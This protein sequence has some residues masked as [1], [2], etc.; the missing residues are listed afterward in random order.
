[1]ITAPIFPNSYV[2]FDF[3]TSGLEPEWCQVIQMSALKVIN[4]K[5]QPAFNRFVK[6]PKKL[7]KKITE[8]TGITDE[9]LAVEG[10]EAGLAWREFSEY[11]GNYA[12]VGHNSINFDRLFLEAAIKSGKAQKVGV[13]RHIDTAMLYKAHKM[14][15][16][17][18]YYESHF[19]FATRI[20]MI[21]AKG[22]YFKLTLC[23]QELGI[24]V[25]QFTAHQSDSDCEMTN[26][27]YR[28]IA[29]LD[30]N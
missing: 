29:Q 5:S 26:L 11:I 14:G 24:D 7:D 2:V 22:V 6:C 30:Q 9:R 3:E 25:T 16:R 19:M 28:K 13:S 12:L 4:G 27:L 23:M 15:E 17:Q 1:M 18:K 21:R 10:I 20:G 8:L